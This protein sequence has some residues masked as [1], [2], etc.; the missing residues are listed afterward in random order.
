MTV[1]MRVMSAGHGYKYLLRSVVRGDGDGLTADALTRYY[2]N[3]GTPPGRWLGQ[4]VADLG[5][6]GVRIAV[7]DQATEEQTAEA[8]Q[9][10]WTGRERL[11]AEYDHLADLAQQPRWTHV[12]ADALVAGGFMPDEA[13][14]L[15]R[16]DSG[17]AGDGAGMD[18]SRATAFDALRRDL[19]KPARDIE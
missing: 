6:D 2:A 7:G 14:A 1:S 9:E 15:L 5:V 12:V 13:R 19:E 17:A 3:P 16:S 11:V 4:G 18:T 10:T 8:Q